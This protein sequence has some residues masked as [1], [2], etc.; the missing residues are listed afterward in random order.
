[1]SIDLRALETRD[2]QI[3]FFDRFIFIEYFFRYDQIQDEST[4]GKSQVV[5]LV[6]FGRIGTNDRQDFKNAV[7][8]MKG[9]TPETKLI[10]V[11]RHSPISDFIEFVDDPK[12]DIITLQ[13]RNEERRAILDAR[14]IYDRISKIPGHLTF[15][16]CAGPEYKEWESEQTLQ[17][18]PNT[19]RT[20]ILHP[21]QFWSSED[22]KLFFNVRFN[23]ANICWSRQNYDEFIDDKAQY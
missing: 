21:R 5:V 17:I 16:L 12:Q 8:R 2:D 13:L 22:L 18:I 7:W 11:T 15:G 4:R 19:Q 6:S 23:S 1:M 14:R 10:I 3:P 9:R 20:L